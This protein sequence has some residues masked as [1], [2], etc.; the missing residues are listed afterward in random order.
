MKEFH[1]MI[2]SLSFQFDF[3]QVPIQQIILLFLIFHV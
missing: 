3:Y 2:Q 1:Y